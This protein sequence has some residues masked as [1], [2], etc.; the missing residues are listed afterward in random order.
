MKLSCGH[1]E[2]LLRA[3]LKLS[4]KNRVA[5]STSYA[6]GQH[7]GVI[8]CMPGARVCHHSSED[9]GR[10]FVQLLNIVKATRHQSQVGHFHSMGHLFLSGLADDACRSRESLLEFWPLRPFS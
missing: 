8:G 5:S 7:L 10:G 9:Q 3:T 6:T 2:T 1:A 4:C